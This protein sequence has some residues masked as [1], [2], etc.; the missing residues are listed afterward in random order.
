[1]FITVFLLT[2][3]IVCLYGIF[4]PGAGSRASAP[5]EGSG[6]PNTLGGYLLFMFAICLGIFIYA[7]DYRWKISV[8]AVLVFIMQPFLNT[9]SRGS[10]LAFILM[11]VTIVIFS[12]KLKTI[13]VFIFIFLALSLPFILPEN[14]I[15]RVTSTFVPGITYSTP[16]GMEVTLD[17]STSQRIEIWK[18]VRKAISRNPILGTGVGGVGLLD[19]QFPKVIA[20]TGILG[21]LAFLW[22]LSAIFMTIKKVYK[23]TECPWSKGLSLGFLAGFI[24]LIVHSFSAET[25]IIIRIMEPFWFIL[26]M[27]VSSLSFTDIQNP[28][29][30]GS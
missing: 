21:I 20:E 1:M 4:F 17:A 11:Y 7:E 3:V 16:I 25:F 13:L 10:Y 6:E 5:F 9:L 8:F 2:C 22:L 26:A 28:T 29:V 27:V 19:S 14:V 12:K 18:D 24:G 23:E 30:Q 15:H